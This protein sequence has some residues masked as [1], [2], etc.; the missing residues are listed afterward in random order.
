VKWHGGFQS[1]LVQYGT[2]AASNFSATI[3]DPTPFTDRSKR[4]LIT[5]QMLF[6]PNDTFAIMPIAI[7][8]RTWDGNPEHR[9]DEWI[10]FGARPELFFTRFLSLAIEGGFDH[11][12]SG[13]G[14]YEGWL[15]KLTIAPQIGAGRQF[16][17]R[18]VLRGFATYA[19]W[20]EGLRGLVGGT[21]FM[22]RRNGLT[23]GVQLETWW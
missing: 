22:N 2:G 16:F 11:T 14:L 23:Y 4:L 12:R 13:T 5:G 18:P 10:S 8:Q 3:D 19:N 9:W 6:Q 17:S 7:Y 21:P 1:I 20:S 15:R